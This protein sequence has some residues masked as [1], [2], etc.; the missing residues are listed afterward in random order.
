M[1]D[2]DAK[3]LALSWMVCEYCLGV[4]RERGCGMCEVK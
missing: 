3:D 1:Q 2:G 4:C